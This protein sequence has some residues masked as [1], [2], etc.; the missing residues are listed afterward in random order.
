MSIF[1]GANGDAL[2]V[3]LFGIVP[4][5]SKLSGSVKKLNKFGSGHTTIGLISGFG[6]FG[7]VN[8]TLTTPAFFVGSAP[9]SVA[10]LS[11]PNAV[12]A[13]S[14]PTTTVTPKKKTPRGPRVG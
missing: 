2:A 11:D 12:S 3:N 1:R 14:L 5:K 7:D 8:S 4:H 9:V 13:L 10:S 6:E